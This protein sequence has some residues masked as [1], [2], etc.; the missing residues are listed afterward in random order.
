MNQYAYLCCQPFFTTC[1]S[2]K[3]SQILQKLKVPQ[4]CKTQHS[5]SEFH[6]NSASWLLFNLAATGSKIVFCTVWFYFLKILLFMSAITLA[7]CSLEARSTGNEFVTTAALFTCGLLGFA[8][9]MAASVITICPSRARF[10]IASNHPIGFVKCPR[11][12]CDL[13][14]SSNA[15]DCGSGSAPSWFVSIAASS[16]EIRLN[17]DSGKTS[18]ETPLTLVPS[19]TYV[20]LLIPCVKLRTLR[21]DFRTS[22]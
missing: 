6:S 4:Q 12:S 13:S 16:S 22:W 2:V 8:A 1:S 9:G 11:F 5:N 17:N 7:T 3:R 18:P 19:D 14:I 21:F 10:S 15:N 20:F